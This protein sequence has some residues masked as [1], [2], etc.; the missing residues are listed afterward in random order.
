MIDNNSTPRTTGS[1]L[2]T[3]HISRSNRFALLLEN[4]PNRNLTN[5]QNINIKS[6]KNPSQAKVLYWSNCCNKPVKHVDKGWGEGMKKSPH[7]LPSEDQKDRGGK[8]K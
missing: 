7:F 3:A 4:S 6:E 8:E 2:D 5:M 1:I